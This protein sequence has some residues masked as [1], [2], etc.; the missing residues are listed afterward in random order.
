MWLQ[1]RWPLTPDPA[2][3]DPPESS[4]GLSVLSLR[5]QIAGADGLVLELQQLLGPELLKGKEPRVSVGPAQL[6]ATSR[7]IRPN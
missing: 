5:G 7:Q 2:P 1:R 4:D 6:R 3:K